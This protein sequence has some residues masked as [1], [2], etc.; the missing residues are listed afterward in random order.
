MASTSRKALTG[1]ARE[2]RRQKREQVQNDLRSRS[3]GMQRVLTEFQPDAVEIE[4]RSVPGGARWT[5]YT[6]CLL[7][8]SAVA[9]ACWAEV[10]RLVMTTGRVIT[11]DPVIIPGAPSSA[12]I[13]SVLVRFGDIVKRGDRLA[14]LDPQIS[15]SDVR[16][17]EVRM[18]G[19]SA[20]IARLTAEQNGTLFSLENHG[21]SPD[22]L[23]QQQLFLQRQAEYKAK[24]DEF[25]SE[26]M[27]LSVQKANA[28]VE[29]ANSESRRASL[30]EYRDTI[31]RLLENGNESETNFLSAKLTVQQE[32]TQVAAHRNKQRELDAE[33]TVVNKRRDAFIAGWNADVADKLQK[34]NDELKGL[35]EELSKARTKAA[36]TTI[37]VP[38]DAAYPEYYVLE[39]ADRNL[40]SVVQQGEALFKLAPLGSPMEVEMELPSRDRGRVR[41][42]DQV[43]IKL[44][45]YPYQKHGYLTGR[46]TTISEGTESDKSEGSEPAKPPFYR[47]RV[48]IDNPTAL[49]NVDADFRLIP[50]MTCECE[51]K[52]GRR[53]VIE[54]FLYPLWRAFD[55]SIREP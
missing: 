15:D 9:W 24:M 49:Q 53:R 22:W 14:T 21:Q 52:V 51:I 36:Y 10:D 25:E 37:S 2:T 6:V 50:D 39:V 43:N 3:S 13:Q 5:L 35:E 20:N 30:A 1:T 40:G 23:N 12:P 42:N 8:I 33:S 45:A 54:Y 11:I 48:S 17:I 28:E 32:E 55:A 31:R 27:K 26:L 38:L 7:L 46:I 19:I 4:Q 16:Q 29:E 18:A 34:A 47:A 41:V 44:S